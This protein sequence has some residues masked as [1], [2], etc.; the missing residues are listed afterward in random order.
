M[1][2]SANST[3][4]LFND[5]S[6]FITQ[7]R[8]LLEQGAIMELA[9]L[10]EQVRVLCDAVLQLSQSERLQYAE[11]LQEMLTGLKLLGDEMVT[12][13]DKIAEEIRGVSNFKKA[14]VAYRT[15]NASDGYEEDGD[16]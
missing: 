12:S 2:I 10:D 14:S 7:S 1:T 16:N 11:R 13:R 8:E 15:V 3:E 4:K 9:G 5:I 6:Q